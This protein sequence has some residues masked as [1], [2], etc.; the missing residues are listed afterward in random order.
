MRR[1]PVAHPVHGHAVEP[2]LRAEL[3]EPRRL[4]VRG[5]ER[6]ALARREPGQRFAVDARSPRVVHGEAYLRA[7][8]AGLDLGLGLRFA[9]G[10]LAL[11][12]AFSAGLGGSL[13]AVFSAFGCIRLA[14][15]PWRR[16][17]L[18][19][20]VSALGLFLVGAR[21]VALVFLVALEVRFVPARA[22]QPEH[23]RGHELLEPLL[24]AAWALR[25][26]LVVDL[27]QHFFVVAAVWTFVF[28][29]RHGY[30]GRLKRGGLWT[31]CAYGDN[32]SRDDQRRSCRKSGVV[33]A[34]RRTD[35]RPPEPGRRPAPRT[36]T[37]G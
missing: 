12:L 26:R 34:R 30:S 20:L 15:R 35:N 6:F 22:L 23:G 16:S 28:V 9:A 25:E 17:W 27:L 1:A 3:R 5:R 31:S 2:V 32:H 21:E 14:R 8:R 10:L 7:L 18:P 37:R 11:L 24:A 4:G 33:S 13:F 19:A 29:E 36:D